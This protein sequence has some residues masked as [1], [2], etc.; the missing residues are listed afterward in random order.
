MNGAAK[1]DIVSLP[2]A[3]NHRHWWCVEFVEINESTIKSSA[4]GSIERWQRV[5]LAQSIIEDINPV[6]MREHPVELISCAGE[7]L[8]NRIAMRINFRS[9][10][11]EFGCLEESI[12][13]GSNCIAIGG[14]HINFSING[15]PSDFLS[16]VA[17]LHAGLIGVDAKSAPNY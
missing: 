7:S 17:V 8:Y 3:D 2:L 15:Q 4:A 5:F 11:L 16:G 13:H 9:L 1:I 6:N 14:G 10:K 12:N